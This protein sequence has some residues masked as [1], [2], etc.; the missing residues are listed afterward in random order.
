MRA[1]AAYHRRPLARKDCGRAVCDE[2][3][4]HVDLRATL[5]AV[6]G[7]RLPADVGV[8]S[9]NALPTLLDR[10]ELRHCGKRPGITSGQI[11]PSHTMNSEAGCAQCECF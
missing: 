1:G 2:T 7:A 4:C 5:A 10:S 11:G 6:L 8:D 3:I 9:V